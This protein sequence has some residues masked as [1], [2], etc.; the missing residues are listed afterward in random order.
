MIR[1]ILITAAVILSPFAPLRAGSAHALHRLTMAVFPIILSSA[2][3]VSFD[4]ACFPAPTQ[5]GLKLNRANT[6]KDGAA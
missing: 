1:V 2:K 3:R 6:G 4:T 5:D